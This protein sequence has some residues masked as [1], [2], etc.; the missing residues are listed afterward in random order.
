MVSMNPKAMLSPLLA[1]SHVTCIEPSAPG[2][3]LS[4]VPIAFTAE[5]GTSI[6]G[7]PVSRST[8]VCLPGR[9]MFV[10]ARLPLVPP[11]IASEVVE[12][13]KSVACPLLFSS[14]GNMVMLPVNLAVSIPP[15]MM[16]PSADPGRNVS[17][18]SYVDREGDTY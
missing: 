11:V 1:V 16:E 18:R 4:A 5:S 3:A 6:E 10:V 13:T 15:N 9:A 7:F 17:A 14:M 8:G 12:I 2:F